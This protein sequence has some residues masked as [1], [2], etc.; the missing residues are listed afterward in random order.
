MYLPDTNVWIELLKARNPDLSLRFAKVR[1]DDISVASVVR[2]ELMHGAWKYRAPDQRRQRLA[3]M[4]SSYH[5]L[6]FDDRC[7]DA[8]AAVRHD[9][10]IRGCMIGPYDLQIA[11]IALVHGLKVVTGNISEF[12]RVS[13]LSVED[14]SS[15]A[16]R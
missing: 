11:A 13:G 7:A 3:G 2:S 14:W 5:S 1:A 8:F 9:L 15:P 6:P 16:N 12:S 10:E 4:L